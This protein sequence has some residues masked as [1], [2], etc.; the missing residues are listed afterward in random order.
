MHSI[1]QVMG[2]QNDIQ[3]NYTDLSHAEKKEFQE[4][5][6]TARKHDITPQGI[7]PTRKM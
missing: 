7:V 4:R 3:K 1:H 5:M 6:K 2:M